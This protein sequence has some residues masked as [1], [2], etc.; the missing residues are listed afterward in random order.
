MDV[1]VAGG[2]ALDDMNFF[3]LPSR[4]GLINGGIYT[5]ISLPTVVIP[6][7]LFIFFP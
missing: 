1:I 3:S 2:H 6:L 5:G 7:I 4:E